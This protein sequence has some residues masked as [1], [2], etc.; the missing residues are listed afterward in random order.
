[1][2]TGVICEA[3]V[4][5]GRTGV[6]RGGWH[7]LTSAIFHASVTDWLQMGACRLFSAV[8]GSA[9]AGCILS[10]RPLGVRGLQPDCQN[11]EASGC[12]KRTLIPKD[13]VLPRAATLSSKTRQP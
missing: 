9:P 13:F 6:S 8:L 11:R 2:K 1:M 12:Y 10:L 4:A 3:I 5:G 7:T